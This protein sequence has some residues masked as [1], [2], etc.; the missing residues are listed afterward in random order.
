[1]DGTS[2]EATR[3]VAECSSWQGHLGALSA[4]VSVSSGT[5]RPFCWGHSGDDASAQCCTV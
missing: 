2:P 4:G 5:D 3:P 1:M